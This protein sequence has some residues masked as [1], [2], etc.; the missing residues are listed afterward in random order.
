MRNVITWVKELDAT[1]VGLGVI[2]LIGVVG[3]AACAVLFIY[4]VSKLVT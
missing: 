2:M 4:Y 3:M 1:V